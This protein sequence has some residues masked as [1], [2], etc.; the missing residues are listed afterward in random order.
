MLEQEDYIESIRKIERLK[1]RIEA[2]KLVNDSLCGRELRI[3]QRAWINK[4][5]RE[6]EAELKKIEN[7]K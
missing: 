3:K 4:L 1:G 7:D 5:R 2:L 6:F